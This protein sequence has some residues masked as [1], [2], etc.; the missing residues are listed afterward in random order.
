M[1]IASPQR[2]KQIPI[3]RESAPIVDPWNLDYDVHIFN[4]LFDRMN[5]HDS[6]VAIE[7]SYTKPIPIDFEVM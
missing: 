5:V 6:R 7:K 2:V 3:I 4:T 1:T